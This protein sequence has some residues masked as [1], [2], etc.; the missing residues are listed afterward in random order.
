MKEHADKRNWKPLEVL[1]LG[2]YGNRSCAKG[3]GGI[4]PGNCDLKAI[5]LCDVIESK[6]KPNKYY[7]L[8]NAMID[9]GALVDGCNEQ[10]IPLAIAVNCDDHDLAVALLEK[11]ANPDG[12]LKSK[13]GKQ[14]DTPIHTAFRIGLSLGNACDV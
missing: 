3:K 5:S 11:N 1:L 4:I 9:H 8:I 13:F 14:Y 7:E 12:L 10:D 2:G 6:P